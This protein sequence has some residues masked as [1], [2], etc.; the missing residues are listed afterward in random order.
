MDEWKLIETAEGQL[1]DADDYREV[2]LS[3]G[4]L[5]RIGWVLRRTSGENPGWCQ[6]ISGTSGPTGWICPRPPPPSPSPM[7]N[8][9]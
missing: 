5:R 9:R 3:D 8:E 6:V 1:P 2:L 7:E 4:E